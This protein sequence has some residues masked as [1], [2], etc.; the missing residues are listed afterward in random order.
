MQTT[1]ISPYDYIPP[2]EAPFQATTMVT[3]DILFAFRPSLSLCNVDITLSSTQVCIIPFSNIVRG[4]GGADT[5]SVGITVVIIFQSNF[6]MIAVPVQYREYENVL[7]VHL[8]LF[9]VI[10]T[11]GNLVLLYISYTKRK[12]VEH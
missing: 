10:Y 2:H 4:N 8:F 3:I 9:H 6:L 12:I 1:L 11:N 5:H 7:L